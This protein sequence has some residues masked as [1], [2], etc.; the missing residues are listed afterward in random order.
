MLIFLALWLFIYLLICVIL[1]QG[2]A[3]DFRERRREEEEREEE[4]H[5]C[6]TET[7]IGPA[8]QACALTGN[9]TLDFSI[10]RTAPNQQSHTSQEGF[11]VRFLLKQALYLT[12]IYK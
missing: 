12:E 2:H 6:E 1:T 10:G 8:T 4:K 3:Y 5:W 7:W 11:S 9:P